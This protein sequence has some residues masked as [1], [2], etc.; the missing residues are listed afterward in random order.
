MCLT[1]CIAVSL[2]RSN[3]D[4]TR[5][6]PPERP[7]RDSNNPG[8]EL[9][10]RQSAGLP[11]THN[12]KGIHRRP[13][14]NEHQ[15]HALHTG[16]AREVYPRP[17]AT[18]ANSQ[19]TK[20]RIYQTHALRHANLRLTHCLKRTPPSSAKES[21]EHGN[22]T[23]GATISGAGLTIFGQPPISGRATP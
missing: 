5:L 15:Q 4:G 20:H 3:L 6:V 12:F 18:E 16:S 2:G 17:R 1:R 8:W 11:M 9:C 19:P 10:S 13:L 14:S 21:A 22:P 7:R 23:F